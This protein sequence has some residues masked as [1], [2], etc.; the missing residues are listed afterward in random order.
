MLQLPN[1]GSAGGLGVHMLA[2]IAAFAAL[3]NPLV[4]QDEKLFDGTGPHT[5]K[6]A[7]SVPQAQKY[8]DQ[9]M[10]FL[11][12]FNHD[13]AIRSL[14]AATRLDPKSAMAWWGLAMA[15]GPHVNNAFVPP[16]REAAGTQAMVKAMA[17]RSTAAPVDKALIEAGATRFN[18]PGGALDRPTLDKNFAAAMKGV[19][20]RFPS[21]ADVAVLYAEALMDLQP[22][23]YWTDGKPKGA[24]TEICDLLA[25]A[26]ALDPKHPQACHLTVHAWEASP[27]PEK[28]IKAAD[29]LRD[30]QPALGHMVHMPSHTDVRVGAWEKA[31]VSNEK[32]IAADET[33]SKVRP[34]IGFYRLYMS[35][36]RHMLGHAAMMVGQ[37]K[38]AIQAMD[39]MAA[40]I[41]P[42]ALKEMGGVLD[43]YM[44]M[45][46]EVRVRFGKWDEILAMPPIPEGL[47]LSK[48]L[49][50]QARGVAF[51]AKGDIPA[52]LAEEKLFLEAQKT[53]PESS[54]MGMNSGAA[55]LAVAESLLRGEILVQEGK[56]DEGIK[57]LEKAVAAEDQL[58]YDEPPDWINPCR[59]PLG[60]ALMRVGRYRE[61][62]KVYQEDLRR[63]PG[64]GWSLYGLSQA[65]KGAGNMRESI[66]AMGKFTSIWK[67]ADTKITSSCLCL[68]GK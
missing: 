18:V 25:R 48:A 35:H 17:L 7:T 4:A 19:Y 13:E 20:E 66:E 32:A 64:N 12:G 33:Y 59:H 21:D 37:G 10:A 57:V 49:R 51:A 46:M 8:F 15:N 39:A 5:R 47:P 11:Y 26:L 27:T 65:Y 28:A 50:H 9:G 62:V 23:D 31:V 60:A 36:N 38:K 56:L 68:P 54:S 52:A 2:T 45:P 1:G 24:T 41:P 44:A 58:R 40:A 29:T 22:W 34:K 6:I 63:L 16:D 61:A 43:G 53:L 3:L 67:D 14:E 42:E 30:L 55:I